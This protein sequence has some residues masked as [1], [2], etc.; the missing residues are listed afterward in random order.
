MTEL[1][2]VGSAPV[3]TVG[4]RGT[5]AA[6]GGSHFFDWWVGAEDRWHHASDEPAV[7]QGLA[8]DDVT[9]ETRLR[10][11]GGDAVQRLVAVP[12]GGT[13]VTLA[14]IE[15][16][17]PVPFAV[18][19]VHEAPTGD[20]RVYD[21]V[22]TVDGRAVLRASRSVARVLVSHSVRDARADLQAGE[23]VPPAELDWP[24]RGSVVV[25]IFPLPHTATLR[26]A[27]S[28]PDSHV[29]S[30]PDDLPP[31][32]SVARGWAAHLA[33][34][35]HISV[36]DERLRRVADAAR[37]HLL[38]GSAL[39]VTQ[40]FWT[41]DAE[42]WVPAVAAAALDSW[43]HGSAARELLLNASGP[44]DLAIHA[45]RG[46]AE[47]GALLWA[48]AERLER[49][50]DPELEVALAP[51]LEQV[52]VGLIKRPG[53]FARRRLQPGDV[54]WRAIGL[55]AAGSL[56]TRLG[57]DTVG[58]DIVDALPELVG[59]I[60]LGAPSVA[61]A[62][63]G[64]RIGTDAPSLMPHL[65]DAFGLPAGANPLSALASAATATGAIAH[66][67]RS[68]HPAASA[69]LLLAMRRA[70]VDE[71][72]GTGGLLDFLATPD[73][74]WLGGV[75]EAHAV[76]VT[77]G[78]ASFGARWHGDRPALLWDVAVTGVSPSLRASGLDATWS[79]DEA[80]GEALLAPTAGLDVSA[81]PTSAEVRRGE[82]VEIGDD[83]DSFA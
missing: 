67:A 80:K 26:C 63:G 23:A 16:D 18:A 37:R 27:L 74:A 47:A 46:P 39:D 36:P 13:G 82:T 56:L 4:V 44:D 52:A 81:G 54:A 51:W 77:G 72:A 53:L 5:L 29:A 57:D 69:L 7:R 59:D 6:L 31:I 68:Q 65:V 42:P 45:T 35:A 78:V 9:I 34:A 15:N 30:P 58:P 11:P 55:A 48:W 14:E 20:V 8:P 1:G 73:P 41:I 32:D 61:T 22:V 24:V 70:I 40:P 33:G 28:G 10:V 83:P 75:I 62:L 19:L 50:S 60:D 3:R 76:P 38:T 64:A 17:T 71:P 25:A 79:A 2:I 49:V 12:D 21:N 66:G 43:G